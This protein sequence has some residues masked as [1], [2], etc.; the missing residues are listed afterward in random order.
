MTSE[1]YLASGRSAKKRDDLKLAKSFFLKAIEADPDSFDALFELGCLTG[2]TGEELL[3]LE[4][5]DR[6]IEI[7]PN[8]IPARSN[9]AAVLS[10]LKRLDQA[11]NE[12]KIV[13]EMDPENAG[14]HHLIGTFYKDER[15]DRAKCTMHYKRA[16]E[17]DPNHRS[18]SEM[19]GW[20]ARNRAD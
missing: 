18:K 12:W 11:E 16:L 2:E 1:A 7:H 20:L 6:A 13:I 4:T 14:A 9:R 15:G 5:W 10:R 8:D 17:I 3:S 19:I